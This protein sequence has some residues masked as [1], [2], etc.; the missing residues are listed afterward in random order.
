MA[1]RIER[2]REQVERPRLPRVLRGLRA[3]SEWSLAVRFMAAYL[4]LLVVA[5]LAMG[6]W[7]G[8]QVEAGIVS[9]TAAVTSL[10][11]E[12]FVG[13]HLQTLQT[14]PKLTPADVEALHGLLAGTQLGRNVVSFKVWSRDGEI[15]YSETPELIGQRFPI[16]GDLAASLDG[17]ITADV[18]D[19]SAEE[20]A[21]ER[22]RWTRLVQT[23]VPVRANG[24]GTIIASAEFYQLP[25]EIDAEVGS[26]RLRAWGVVLLA[27]FGSYLLVGFIVRRASIT[28]GR[29]QQRLRD[30][31]ETLSSV[32]REVTDLNQRLHVAAG[33]TI[34]VATQERRRISADLHDGPAQ[35][36]ALA[37]LRLESFQD[38]TEVA[39][40]DD[41]RVNAA[42]GAL[43]DAMGELRQIAAGLRLPDLAPLTVREVVARAVADH[44]RRAGIRI[45]SS[46]AEDLPDEAPLPI[47]I[48]LFRGLQEGLSN[49]T[50]HGGGIDVAVRAWNADG[51]VAVEVSDK[52][53]GF[54]PEAVRSGGLGLTGIRERAALLE[55]N[56]AVQ[57]SP[58]GGTRLR[59]VL[60]IEIRQPD[61]RKPSLRIA[62]RRRG[63]AVTGKIRVVV[64]DD[65]PLF[66]DGLVAAL[67]AAD[68]IDVVGQAGDAAGALRLVRT[69]RPQVVLLDV[70]MPG[71]GLSAARDVGQVSPETRILMLTASEDEDD[72]LAAMKAGASGYA[73]K[74]MP[75]RDLL[76]VVRAVA[77]GEA[78]VAPS[79]AWGM[80]RE[81]TRP[82]P[83][84]AV[85]G[86]S[87]REREVLEYVA[88][89]L[90]NAEIGVRLG[91]AEKTV[92]HYMTGV[93]AKLQVG[94]RVEAAVVAHKAGLVA[95]PRTREG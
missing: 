35:A 78:Y 57:S 48:A 72:I 30:Q 31:V 60:P 6:L 41:T 91:L 84:R 36:M 94:S 71:G 81:M 10:Y 7:V 23:Y 61:D 37:L 73:L 79:L 62:P 67:R 40:H 86:L 22:V 70:T 82:R 68:D 14:Q 76:G 42:Y 28:I 83:G 33:Q 95:E 13:P 88:A 80:L 3:V 21:L 64:A 12:S 32:Y 52:G 45:D 92:K 54:E 34:E 18:S 55:G 66:L 75:A 58:G 27:A 69:H 15:L 53:P 47:K 17:E 9:R 49:A 85:D 89:G 26:A 16:D 24:T 74:G 63:P 87:A 29:Q 65:H 59:I 1:E 4:G 43:R 8:Q 25:D 77:A 20:N 46:L 11:I 51:A 2:V 50:R 38:S 5:T 44:E 19:L 90:S 39:G 56:V 93:L